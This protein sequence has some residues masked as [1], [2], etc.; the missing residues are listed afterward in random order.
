LLDPLPV[1]SSSPVGRSG[2]DWRYNCKVAN[3]CP[4]ARP[5]YI[6]QL[7]T[8]WGGTGDPTPA[9][10][11]T[12]WTTSGRSCSP[13]GNTVVPAGNWYIDCGATGLSTNGTLT[14]QGGNIVSDGPVKATGTG[15]LRVNCTDANTADLIAPATCPTDPP[16]PSI[17]VLRS[18]D[19]LDA[20]KIELRETMV[21]TKTGTAKLAGNN[22][23]IWTAPDD[24]T[25]KFDDL[26]LWTEST[27]L[28]KIT[29][30]TDMEIE[31][32]VF[33]PGAK[34][35]LAGNTGTSA[36]RAQIFANNAELV[37]GSHL[38]LV[39]EEDRILKV[40]KGRPLLIR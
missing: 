12:K 10:S 15:G 13:S 19:L 3:G 9:G 22:R 23:V 25:F 37:G 39:P 38:N 1:A 6:D 24:P 28:V 20:G 2:M 4:D 35:E 32:I 7:V 31:G 27:A 40:G 14:F 33:A 30:T 11:F 36:L 18:G 5:A 21:Y 17:F 8:A 29:G 34:V 26:A 16:S